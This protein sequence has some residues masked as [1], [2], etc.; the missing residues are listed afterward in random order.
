MNTSYFFIESQRLILIP[1]PYN[2]LMLLNDTSSLSKE[3][4][5][6]YSPFDMEEFFV[7][8]FEDAL[9]STWKPNVKKFPENY[10]WFTN[11]VIVLKENNTAI[12]GIGLAGLPNENGE[13]ETGYALDKNYR[14]KGYASEALEVLTD[15]VFM[16]DDAKAIIAHT[17][18]DGSSSQKVLIR[19]NFKYVQ[20]EITDD[21][22][23][24][25]W[26]KEKST[27]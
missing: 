19:N 13:T 5:I 8:G 2:L 3:L 10:A 15:W 26:R 7:K 25:L 4:D 24:M 18:N 20:N 6:H 16:Q 22:D 1:L 11:W 9:E 21:G 14:N 12:G 23:V 17:L 27:I